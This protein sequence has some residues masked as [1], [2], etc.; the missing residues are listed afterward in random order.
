MRGTNSNHPARIQ[1]R[2]VLMIKKPNERCRFDD[3]ARPCRATSMSQPQQRQQNARA[4]PA[5]DAMRTQQ[6]K[7]TFPKDP[8]K[9]PT[10][11]EPRVVHV[12]AEGWG[13]AGMAL[14]TAW[15]PYNHITLQ[16]HTDTLHVIQ[17][18]WPREPYLPAKP[19]E[20]DWGGS[21]ARSQN[22]AAPLLTPSPYSCRNTA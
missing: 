3:K 2:F 15:T 6:S 19:T 12:N 11:P 9:L 5:V 22:N 13:R 1:T 21:Q 20:G 16:T 18:V 4:C 7:L 14:Q 8:A 10:C 17:W